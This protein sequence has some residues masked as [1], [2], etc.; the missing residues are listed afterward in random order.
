MKSLWNGNLANVLRYMPTQAFN[1]AF[2]D[3]YKE[4]FCGGLDKSEEI[5]FAMGSIMA[6][7]LAGMSSYPIVYPLDYARTRLSTQKK[8][9]KKMYKGL[10]DCLVKSVKTDGLKSIYAGYVIANLGIFVYR[11]VQFGCYDIEKKM[12]FSR[13]D[14]TNPIG[15][16]V[17]KT[18]MAFSAATVSGLC[19]YPIDTVR[20]RLFMD[21]GKKEKTYK[22]TMDCFRKIVAQEGLKGLWKGALSNIARGFGATLV[23]VIYDDAKA[24]AYSKYGGH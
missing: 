8:G 20:R 23:L 15:L 10:V 11:G 3:K 22:G 17:L 21:V 18:A 24:F 13:Y 14:V 16:R 2:K 6:G 7:G 19:S 4:F 5:K 9:K 12:I 1:L